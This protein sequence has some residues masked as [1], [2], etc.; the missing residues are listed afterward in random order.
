MAGRDIHQA[1]A[2]LIE[3]NPLLRSVAGQQLRDLGIMQIS[4]TSKLTDARIALER[5]TFDLVLCSREFEGS[6]SSGQDLLDELRREQILPHSTVFIMLTAEVAY[7]QVVEA[8]EASLDGLLVRPFTAGALA[9]RI[10]EA[11][12]RKRALADVLKALDAG[13]LDGAFARAL[14][15]FQEQQPYWAW[16]GRLAAE[17]LLR[18]QRPADAKKLFEKLVHAQ[19]GAWARLGVARASMA[20]ADTTGAR[21]AISAVL[22]DEPECAD[23]HDLMARTLLEQSDFDSA[24]D[25]YRRSATIT[26]GCQLR[27]QHV[28]ALAFYQG[29]TDEAARNLERAVSLGT[30]SKLFDAQ[31]LL[32]LALLRHD[33]GHAQGVTSMLEQMRRYAQ[34]FPAS[35]RLKRME[36]GVRALGYLLGEHPE[37]ALDLVRRLGSEAH[38]PGFDL[39]AALMLLALWAR[40]PQTLH[41]PGE[42]DTV[43]E[44]L[45]LRF[46][47][48]KAIAEVLAAAARRDPV[49]INTIRQQQAL[50]AE[51][52]Q[53]ALDLSL[54]GDVPGAVR[55]LLALGEET[56]NAKIL[57]MAGAL[58][59]R[60]E[61]SFD[62]GGEGLAGRAGELLRT[63]GR[64]STHIAGLQRSGRAP[65]GLQI[66]A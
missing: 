51:R 40:L 53:A 55:R 62:D 1:R 7:H 29:E 65:G 10:T 26:P 12:N 8:A 60:H 17:L 49:A 43:L 28:G 63:W 14:R 50:L 3:G 5:E 66:R 16:C 11:R 22:S 6:E 47:T 30:N 35:R 59:R 54:Q 57:D 61:A 41:P 15:R 9:E 58:L 13:D 46:C 42:H 20:M 32:L 48:S 38:D 33:R 21:Q 52:S 18:M 34:R 25:S 24:L 2:L 19:S 31:T 44:K 36:Q 27:A 37:R 56:R 45:A 39:E 4:Q 64:P 23:A